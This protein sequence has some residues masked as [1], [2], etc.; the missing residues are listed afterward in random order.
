MLYKAKMPPLIPSPPPSH[1]SSFPGPLVTMKCKITYTFRKVI[2]IPHRKKDTRFPAGADHSRMKGFRKR[3]NMSEKERDPPLT[4]V[5]I[6]GLRK[7]VSMEVNCSQWKTC[8]LRSG[9]V[10][11][12]VKS[13]PLYSWEVRFVAP[14]NLQGASFCLYYK[15]PCIG[16]K[17][18]AIITYVN[19][20]LLL[21]ET[22][23][24]PPAWP[25]CFWQVNVCNASTHRSRCV[26]IELSVYWA[27]V[28]QTKKEN[29]GKIMVHGT[30]SQAH[31]CKQAHTHTSTDT[32]I[33]QLPLM[34]SSSASWVCEASPP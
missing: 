26:S 34:N 29:W 4:L 19:T 13:H 3:E 12:G 15:W 21:S 30:F 32:H 16:W 5:W 24:E 18:K 6:K 25:C 7:Y 27:P 28:F 9:K 20:T 22:F 10:L 17:V 23:W 31:M 8:D 2:E 11:W 1:M 33:Q 14:Q